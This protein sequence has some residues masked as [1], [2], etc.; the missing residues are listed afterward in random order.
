MA[1]PQAQGLFLVCNVPQA[2]ITIGAK[3]KT[4]TLLPHDVDVTKATTLATEVRPGY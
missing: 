3:Y 4:M 1:P 2:T